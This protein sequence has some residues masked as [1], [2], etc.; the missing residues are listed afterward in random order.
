MA[1]LCEHYI[2]DVVGSVLVER[3]LL[4]EGRGGGRTDG[5]KGGR[6]KRMVDAGLEVLFCVDDGRIDRS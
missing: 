2:S 3:L 4:L 6:G 5:R 1:T